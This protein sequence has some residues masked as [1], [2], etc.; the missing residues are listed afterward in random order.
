VHCLFAV[1]PFIQHA[2]ERSVLHLDARSVT[3]GGCLCCFVRQ[4]PMVHYWHRMYCMPA[5]VPVNVQMT[6][7]YACVLMPA[8]E[9]MPVLCWQT[10]AVL[11]SPWCIDTRMTKND[12]PAVYRH[13]DERIISCDV[14]HTHRRNAN[15]LISCAEPCKLCLLHWWITRTYEWMPFN[16][17]YRRT[18]T[19]N[20]ACVE[21]SLFHTEVDVR[22]WAS[23]QMHRT[24]ADFSLT[25][26]YNY[27]QW[28]CLYD[29]KWLRI[30]I[31]QC[32]D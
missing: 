21:C 14:S 23:S 5:T 27:Q 29:R 15:I 30:I 16:G 28:L 2:D 12:D 3:T 22:P 19:T 26:E 24:F 4:K 9:Q 10:D 6:C 31:D 1:P 7:H 25:D 8:I 11:V 13:A 20:N 18:M 32:I 17:E